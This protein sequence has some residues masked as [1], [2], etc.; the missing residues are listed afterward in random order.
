MAKILSQHDQ[1]LLKRI[2][3]L[4]QFGYTE[5]PEIIHL[6]NQLEDKNERDFWNRVC[7]RYN[8]LEEASIGAI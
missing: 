3:N 6:A 4:D 5:W 1:D 2:K 8:H 7:I